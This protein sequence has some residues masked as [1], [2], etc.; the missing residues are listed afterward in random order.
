M[1]AIGKRDMC[2]RAMQ[3]VVTGGIKEAYLQSMRRLNC[4]AIDLRPCEIEKVDPRLVSEISS[5][6]WP[7]H[8]QHQ[9]RGN[10]SQ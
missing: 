4:D 1:G 2:A 6:N 9:H 5:D 7:L 8:L 3:D 10:S